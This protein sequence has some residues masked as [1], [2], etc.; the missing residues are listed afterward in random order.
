MNPPLPHFRYHPEPLA[1]GSIEA[2]AT[3]CQC[4]GKARGYV[5]TGSPSPRHELPPGSLCPWC[6]AD[7]SAA[8][9]Y[10]ASFSDDYPLLDAGVAADIVTEV[11]ERTPGYTSWQQ[12]RWL[13]CCEDACAFRGDAG[14]E[15]IGQLGAEGLAQRFA[16][17]AWPAITWQRLVDAYTPGGNPAI[18]RFDCL[19]CGQAHYDLDFT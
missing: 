4:C 15:E 12:E 1:S 7:G 6:I 11:C 3:T 10:E 8:A 18:Y 14:R 17:F 9:R 16:D 19:H 13:V 5:Y 2:S